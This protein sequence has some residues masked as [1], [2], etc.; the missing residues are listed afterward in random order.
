MDYIE[1]GFLGLFLACF[2]SATLLPLA[3]EAVLLLF[4]GANFD[5]MATLWIATA[6]NVMGG[7]T[8]YGIGRLGNPQKVQNYLP[9]P[10]RFERLSQLVKRFG[11]WISLLTW[12]P[13]I[14]DPLTVIL[15]FFRVH[16][17]YFLLL[18]TIG[19]FLRY[20]AIVYFW[21]E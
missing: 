9:N 12:L 3:S 2:L 8:N 18:A 21:L 6:G 11:H 1:L 16:F 4:L 5:P 7:L 15:G 10:K 17:L 13:F 14:G 19:K 20:Y